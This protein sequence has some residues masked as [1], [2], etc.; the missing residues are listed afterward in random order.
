MSQYNQ[1]NQRVDRQYN[2]GGDI[3]MQ[4]H[5]HYDQRFQ[6]QEYV[7]GNKFQVHTQKSAASVLASGLITIAVLL[8]IGAG[9]YFAFPAIKGAANGLLSQGS[10]LFNPANSLD[11]TLYGTP[12]SALDQFCN[13]LRSG[14][15]Q[16]AYDVY[17]DHLKSQVSADDFANSWNQSGESITQC[18]DTII[19]TSNTSATGTLNIATRT[20]ASGGVTDKSFVYHITMVSGDGI[21]K[22]DA[23]S[24]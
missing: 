20:I 4:R 5:T 22:I 9:V 14:D 1:Q 3:N 6:A 23:M 17:T 24:Q 11:R 10:N 16:G 8:L 15:T 2:A 19:N 12:K 18:I 7:G 13:H 21:W